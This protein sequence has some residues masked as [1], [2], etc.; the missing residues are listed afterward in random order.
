MSG[1]QDLEQL[2]RSK[3]KVKEFFALPD[4]EFEFQVEYDE[5][6]KRGFEQLESE[7]S[8]RGYRPELSGSKEECVLS[9][10]KAE[11]EKKDASRFTVVLALFTCAAVVVFAIGEVLNYQQLAPSLSEYYVFFSFAACTMLLFGAHELGQR[12]M[13]TRRKGGH[14]SSYLIPWLPFFPPAPSLGF[15][16]TQRAPALNRDHLF[17]TV[18]AGPLFI[19]ALA[20]VIYAM[21]DITAAQSPLLYQWAHNGNATRLTNSNAVQASMDAILAPVLPRAVPFALPVSPLADAATIGFILV[22]IGL[23]PMATFDGGLLSLSAWGERA[24]RALTYLSAFGL[25]LV[26]TPN[27]WALAVLVLLLAGRNYGLKLLDGVSGLSPS[28]QW[29]FIGTLVLAFLCLPIPHNIGTL[30]LP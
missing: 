27:Y 5:R 4:G 23:L 3:F 28:R 26:D 22:F 18:I 2:V 17:D 13:A 15:T 16:S 12:M 14:A 11:P 20:L 24:A 10:R 6:T 1:Q 21:G 25:L 19:L 29:V 7:A 8:S 30:A 9:I